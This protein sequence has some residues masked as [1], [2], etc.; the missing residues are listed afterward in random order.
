M[1]KVTICD[2]FTTPF[3]LIFHF[4][5]PP[6]TINLQAKFQISSFSRSPDMEGPN[7]LKISHMTL[8]YLQTGGRR[9]PPIWILD[10][11]LP[12]PYTTS[13]GIWWR[14]SVVYRWTS[15]ALRPFWGDV[16]SK[17]RPEIKHF[18]R[19]WGRNVEFGFWDPQSSHP[20]I[21]RRHLTYWPQKSAQR[22]W[23]YS[24][25]RTQQVA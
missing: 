25:A 16:L 10:P 17:N 2:I 23:R 14:L 8:Y 7:I 4:S 6:L 11:D 12:I 15:P 22:A 21:K 19:K 9:W 13:M 18:E 5:L 1:Q 3:D 24:M 20:C